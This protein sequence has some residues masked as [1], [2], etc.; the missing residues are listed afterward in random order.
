MA[1]WRFDSE[2]STTERRRLVPKLM[3]S[4][5]AL[6]VELTMVSLPSGTQVNPLI[7]LVIGLA[8]RSVASG[9]V[10]F[11]GPLLKLFDKGPANTEYKYFVWGRVGGIDKRTDDPRIHN[12]V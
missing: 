10:K 5:A 8:K 1:I 11:D 3:M 2:A 12:S 9:R 7:G 4:P 6:R